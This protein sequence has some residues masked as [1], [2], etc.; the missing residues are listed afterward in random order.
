MNVK[1]GIL[2]QSIRLFVR[3][4]PACISCTV[5]ARSYNSSQ[6]PVVDT[7]GYS[8]LDVKFSNL[9]LKKNIILKNYVLKKDQLTIT[10]S[11]TV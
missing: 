10:F 1:N 3:L 8:Y 4:S 11:L 2:L 7:H 5:I 9:F 6:M